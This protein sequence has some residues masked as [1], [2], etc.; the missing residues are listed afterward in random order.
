MPDWDTVCFNI[1]ALTCSLFLLEFGAD[2]FLKHTAAVSR[3]TG[4]P[5]GVVGLLTAGAEWEEVWSLSLSG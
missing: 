1:A 4:I 3:R 5:E 2:R